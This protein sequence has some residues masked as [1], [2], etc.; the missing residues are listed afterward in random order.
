MRRSGAARFQ[1]TLSQVRGAGALAT[2]RTVSVLPVYSPLGFVIGMP[3]L[4]SAEKLFGA[5]R[6]VPCGLTAG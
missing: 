3:A 4:F 5:A 1:G 2:V 6:S